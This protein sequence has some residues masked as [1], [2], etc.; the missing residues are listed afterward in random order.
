[1]SRWR[2]S[3]A[4]AAA[5]LLLAGCAAQRL[6]SD[7]LDQIEKGK[8]REGLS[9]LRRAAELDQDNPRYRMDYL[10]QR[11]FVV[12]R[13]FYT[14]ELAWQAGKL[15]EADKS[16]REVLELDPRNERALRA[17]FDV[18]QR[19]RADQRVDQADEQIRS[20]QLTAARELLKGVL[21]DQPQHARAKASLRTLEDKA[22]TD[23]AAR[24]DKLGTRAALRKPVT[25]Q[26]RDAPLRQVFEA[27]SRATN[28]N[29]IIDRDVRT[30]LRS[31]IFVKD[32]AVE[33]AIDL[34]L[35]Q[36]NLEK[37][38]LNSNSLMVYPATAAKI[39]EY[40]ELRVRTFQLSNM[41]AAHAANLLKTML[42]TKDVVTD[43][44][45]NT[46]IM[47]DTPEAIAVA[48]QLIAA[49]DVPEPEVML[50]VEVL[51][52]T[53]SRNSEIGVKWPTGITFT[54]P[55][56]TSNNTNPVTGVTTTSSEPLTWGTLRGVTAN[57]LLVPQLAGALNLQLTDSD[58]NILASPRIRA[59]N[60]EKAKIMVG[61]KVPV[62]T[63]VLASAGTGTGTAAAG[64]ANNNFI[65]GSIQYLDV[66]LKLE[67]E[68][69]VYAE[70]DVAIKVN[71]E[72]SNV[73]Q[74]I[75]TQTGTAYQ[76]GTRNAQTV[77]R[78]KDGETQVLA[79]LINNAD[80]STA[81]KV[82]G[83]GQFPVLGRLFS[84][85]KDDKTKTEIVLSITP[86]IIRPLL[87]NDLSRA[88]VFVGSEAAI[89]SRP[90]RVEPIE[91]LRVGGGTSGA[92]PMLLPVPAAAAA[93]PAPGTAVVAAPGT[94]AAPAP[95]VA[96]AAAPAASAAAAS[97]APQKAV[98]PAAPV[99]PVA[100]SRPAV[101]PKVGTS[102]NSPVVI[103]PA[104]AAAAS[105]V[106]A[107]PAPLPPPPGSGG[108]A[109]IR[110]GMPG[111]PAVMPR[112]MPGR[113]VMPPAEPPAA[114]APAEPAPAEPVEPE[115]DAPADGTPE[116]TDTPPGAQ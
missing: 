63:N 89:R 10:N 2:P 75:T 84:N 65:T 102:L 27:I 53:T 17:L 115:A 86:R 112:N 67:V 66:G 5:A 76:I 13:L 100:P 61:D 29:I 20:G 50:E 7:G 18:E 42:K 110:S 38:A 97:V 80:R 87:V 103:V 114:P 8:S 104:P 58:T 77:L 32:A 70:G 28:L 91:V 60:K 31:T 54:T 59:R 96:P 92:G 93:A 98:A 45:T 40:G 106:P 19:R 26:F 23:Q 73:A 39:K 95:A 43:V 41:E 25:L 30:D 56:P 90:L 22:A 33:D 68:P 74:T 34:I 44:R 71:L 47:R 49:N 79:G 1:M 55:N 101:I 3:L 88:D 64:A 21:R 107:K 46:L 16:L 15:D 105:G 9:S 108:I 62:I 78:L 37:R 83:L 111:V 116:P 72:V 48:E 6:H 113:A 57:S 109:P 14:A 99:A 36:S 4:A 24:E 82:P 51:E 35:L 94:V 11:Q 85:N 12:Q 52:V 69:Q 81:A